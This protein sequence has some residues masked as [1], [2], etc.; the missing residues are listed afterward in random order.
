[1]D[2]NNS[3]Y[4][5]RDLKAFRDTFKQEGS[6]RSDRY[7]PVLDPGNLF[8]DNRSLTDLLLYAR[9]YAANVRF[10]KTAAGDNAADG[11]SW[12]A[13]FSEDILSVIAN[14]AATDLAVIKDEYSRLEEGFN[15]SPAINDLV[16]VMNFLF[17]RFTRLNDWYQ[18]ADDYAPLKEDL[19]L[20]IQSY[21]APRFLDLYEV[22]FLLRNAGED[23]NELLQ[24]QMELIDRM[25]PVWGDLN[26]VNSRIRQSQQVTQGD[27]YELEATMTRLKATYDAVYNVT[28]LVKKNNEGYLADLLHNRQNHPAHI[29]LLVTFLQLYGYPQKALNAL[30][31]KHLDFYYREVLRVQPAKPKPDALYLLFELSE[32]FTGLLVNAQTA[33]SAGKDNLKTDQVYKTQKD[34]TVQQSAVQVI[35]TL[36]I[37]K[38]D[39]HLVTGYYENILT[40]DKRGQAATAWSSFGDAVAA[41]E[42]FAGC[43]LASAQLQLS[44]GKRNIV[45]RFA[46]DGTIP[47]ASFDKNCFL[48]QFTGQK[49]WLS[50]AVAADKVVINSVETVL[51]NGHTCFVVNCTVAMEQESAITGYNKQLHGFNFNTSLPVMLCQLVFPDTPDAAAQAAAKPAVEQLNQLLDCQLTGIEVQVTVGDPGDRDAATGTSQLS[52]RNDEAAVDSTKPFFPFTGIPRVGASFYITCTEMAD[53]IVTA[54][55]LHINW[56]LPENF[57]SYY[58]AYPPPYNGNIF[59]VAVSVLYKNQWLTVGDE[60]ILDLNAFV[61]DPSVCVITVNFKDIP[62]L[63]EEPL[64]EAPVLR[65]QLL[66]PDFGHGIY[67]QIVTASMLQQTTSDAQS[68]RA[69]LQTSIT[70]QLADVKM[71]VQLPDGQGDWETNMQ[72]LNALFPQGKEPLTDK[73]GLEE[74]KSV[75]AGNIK[76]FNQTHTVKEPAVATPGAAKPEPAGLR[77]VVMNFRSLFKSGDETLPAAVDKMDADTKLGAQLPAG[78]EMMSLAMGEINQTIHKTV[79]SVV[80]DLHNSA[81]KDETDI[82]QRFTDAFTE[83]NQQLPAIIAKKIVLNM[84]AADLP[85]QPYTP[86][87]QSISLTYTAERAFATG[88]DQFFHTVAAEA[89]TPA[90]NAGANLTCPLFPRYGNLPVAAA[91]DA[92]LLLGLDQVPPEGNLSFL[93]Q[94]VEGTRRTE[95]DPPPVAWYY[96]SGNEWKI[97]SKDNLVSDNT[98]TLQTTGIQVMAMPEDINNNGA[99]QGSDGLY[100]MAAVISGS[101]KAFPLMTDV[102]T[103]AVEA[104]FVDQ[105][106]DPAHYVLPLQPNKA[107]KLL[108][109]IPAVKKITQPMASFGAQVAETGMDYYV[110]VSERLRHKQRGINAWDY[111]HLVLGAFPAVFKV[112]C[113]SNYYN[114]QTVRGHV[115]VVPICDLRNSNGAG[116][117]ILYPKAS[118]VLLKQIEAYLAQRISPFVKIHAVNPVT[119]QVLVNCKVKFKTGVDKGYFLKQLNTDLVQFLTPWANGDMNAVSFSSKIYAS[120]IIQFMMQTSYV[121]FVSDMVMNQYSQDEAGNIT[122]QERDNGS[123]SLL[124]TNLST[125]HSILVSAPKHNLQLLE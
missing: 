49:T 29:A 42:V 24:W 41:N 21:L 96:L 122:Y 74:I 31:A 118:Y 17:K 107:T 109:D 8:L 30:P 9:S 45:I 57:R 100:W 71:T 5:F 2:I 1:M 11:T 83:A 77:K 46:L 78:H 62:V 38:N 84:S 44:Q 69:A 56:Q 51:D 20:Y 39:D 35:K 105:G 59:K 54:A 40:K 124:E 99:V 90:F 61:A 48:V 82:K 36:C 32:G 7:S 60:T 114:G 113:I 117:D 110:R 121:E 87:V 3:H 23:N 13:F 108:V 79:K 66:Y 123:I 119:D 27:A 76:T 52:L 104:L 85:A 68:Q 18:H 33:V 75:I 26:E 65:L 53:K 63:M 125:R 28:G 103:N 12:E 81:A 88:I 112:K 4:H 80:D 47:A 101:S 50:S 25:H 89:W 73:R 67:P 37:D 72:N 92:A 55:E 116:V 91:P 10:Y 102:Q 43:A 58:S 14:I 115:T 64:A 94:F 15:N 95:A 86:L 70:K 16:R 19:E 111:E 98:M 106:N 6:S 97:F 22:S 34:L 93:F 120:S